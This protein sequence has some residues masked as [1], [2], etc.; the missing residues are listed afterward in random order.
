MIINRGARWLV[1]FQR[2]AIYVY[3]NVQ[4]FSSPMTGTLFIKLFAR[5]KKNYQPFFFREVEKNG[6][7]LTDIGLFMLHVIADSADSFILITFSFK[8]C[9][10]FRFFKF[11]HF[12]D[13]SIVNKQ[14]ISNF[15]QRKRY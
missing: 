2:L 3:T 15:F 1:Y 11:N 4:K 8:Y 7:Q 10:G 13:S 6:I 9:S 14:T 12:V 5:R